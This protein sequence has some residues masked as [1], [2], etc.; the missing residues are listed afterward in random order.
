MLTATAL[1]YGDSPA[2]TCP[3]LQSFPQWWRTPVQVVGDPLWTLVHLE[4]RHTTW[5]PCFALDM[6]PHTRPS[7]DA[8]C[9]WRRA[10]LAQELNDATLYLLERIVSQTDHVL[11]WYC[12]LS[13]APCS[14]LPPPRGRPVNYWHCCRMCL[15]FTWT[16]LIFLGSHY[17]SALKTPCGNRNIMQSYPVCWKFLVAYPTACWLWDFT[18]LLPKTK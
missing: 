17:S 14:A 16:T 15:C 12:E 11:C 7:F 9:P 6:R 1:L 3:Q 2:P 18:A 8:K 5:T 13:A 4:T 10:F